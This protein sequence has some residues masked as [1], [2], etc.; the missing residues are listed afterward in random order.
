MTTSKSASF[1]IRKFFATVVCFL[2]LLCL[3]LA[4]MHVKS[5]HLLA[6]EILEIQVLSPPHPNELFLIKVGQ[7]EIEYSYLS[8]T[9][10]D[11]LCAPIALEGVR[12]KLSS[13][14]AVSK[15]GLSNHTKFLKIEDFLRQP[16]LKQC[17]QV[18]LSTSSPKYLIRAGS[19]MDS[20]PSFLMDSTGY[21][22]SCIVKHLDSRQEGADLVDAEWVKVLT[23]L[24]IV[25]KDLAERIA[26]LPNQHNY[27]KFYSEKKDKIKSPGEML[28]SFLGNTID[29]VSFQIVEGMLMK[30]VKMLDDCKTRTSVSN[31]K[32]FSDGFEELGSWVDINKK[33]AESSQGAPPA[34]KH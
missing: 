32:M 23:A 11:I 1:R 34:I 5:S 29:G 4:I 33:K 31:I 26:I 10:C 18:S 9:S 22:D 25:K 2:S 6:G 28:V 30:R 19:M 20:E 12:I 16:T 24:D 17:L 21:L 3:G 14:L 27:S 7:S 8:D 13:P 15:E